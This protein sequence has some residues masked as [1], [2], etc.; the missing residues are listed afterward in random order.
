MTSALEKRLRQLKDS[1]QKGIIPFISAG[2]PDIETTRDIILALSEAGASAI[3]IGVPFSD[4]IA[5][6][7]T[8]QAAGQ[9]A[10]EAGASL[11]R[12]LDMLRDLP[13]EKTAPLVVFSYLNPIDRMGFENFARRAKEAGV[14][15][16]LLT[17]ATPGTEPDL[18]AQ[19][20]E[21]ELDLICLVAP[22]TPEVRLKTIAER[23]SGFVYMIARRGVTGK[24]AE[25]IEVRGNARRLRE[26]TDLPLYIGF[27]VRSR[28]DVLRLNDEADGVIVGSALVQK[29]HETD[30][31]QRA[32]VAGAFLRELQGR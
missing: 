22:T 8:I 5:D 15:A 26:L 14:S 23:G 6:G 9:R 20:T 19:L 17:D 29:L 10:I 28:E 21:N 2:D 32:E 27:G 7:P 1:G 31:A 30:R 25:E 3:E 11:S 18:E 24:G 16:L 4:P 12:I 13:K